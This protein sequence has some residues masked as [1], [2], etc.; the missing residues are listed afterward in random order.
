MSRPFF[1]SSLDGLARI[2]IFSI[3]LIFPIVLILWLTRWGIGIDN[4]STVYISSAFN[5]SRGL[6]LSEWAPN[7]HL[8]PM[9]HFP[10]LYP[11]VLSFIHKFG[12]NVL[13]SIRLLN[14]LLLS[15]NILLVGLI[16]FKLTMHKAS[17]FIAGLLLIFS[18]HI[19]LIHMTAM[20]EPFFIFLFLLG[21]FFFLKYTEGL[22]AQPLILA[23][24]F[25]GLAMLCR[26]IGIAFILAGLVYILIWG[27]KP[28]KKRML[29]I[30]LFSFVSFPGIFMWFTR[31]MMISGIF[32]DRSLGFYPAT[33]SSLLKAGQ[34]ILWWLSFERNMPFTGYIRFF[35]LIL[36]LLIPSL[37]VI[38]K[39]KRAS[40]E[41][42]TLP[43]NIIFL[44]LCLGSYFIFLFISSL[45]FDPAIMLDYRILSPSYIILV[46]LLSI[47][48][49]WINFNRSIRFILLGWMLCNLIYIYEWGRARTSYLIWNS[50]QRF[51]WEKMPGLKIINGLPDQ[52]IFYTNDPE[53]LYSMT[54]KVP[55]LLNRSILSTLTPNNLQNNSGSIYL[56]FF[57]QKVSKPFLPNY[58]EI[59]G[60]AFYEL[61]FESPQL[62]MCR[63]DQNIRF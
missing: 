56:I 53:L 51:N 60:I 23:G 55:A 34:T 10:P 58:Q 12:I 42:H 48:F 16:A 6:G 18:T 25:W 37:S 35:L 15:G 32:A 33:N 26:Y 28:F 49:N 4:D 5:L 62:Y 50:Y 8:R 52:G 43:N 44:L 57:K 45:F 27:A 7:G 19:L 24:L 63:V 1:S 40:L 59:K 39:I 30:S 20:T 31:N 47:S 14:G 61:L 46:L 38:P 36:I 11:L 17:A 41:K 21:I 54:G 22:T 2:L 13:T 9:T 3:L 29:H